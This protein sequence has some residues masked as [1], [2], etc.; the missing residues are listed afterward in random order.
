MSRRAPNLF[1]IGSMK[2]GTTYLAGL[3]AE[4]PAVFM[5]EPKEPCHFVD[6]AVL[7]RVWPAAWR[8]GYWRS[9]ELYLSL[10]AAAGDARIVGEASTAYSQVPLFDG[11]PERILSL[12][13]ESRFIYIMRDP[14]ERAISHYWHV[15][16]WWAERRDMMTAIRRE[17]HYADVSHYARQLKAYLRYVPPER[18]YT[19]TLEQL[20]AKPYE[21]VRALCFWLGIEPDALPVTMAGPL[22]LTP[23]MIEQARGFGLLHRL[24]RSSPYSRIGRFVPRPAR[25]LFAQMA[26]RRV[27]PEGEPVRQV[28]EYLRPRMQEQTQELCA[29][30]GRSFP[31][32]QTLYGA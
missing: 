15:V 8:L 27:D 24:R 30:L 31:E 16:R 11:V 20:Q 3:L 17:P 13:P 2:S 19:L 4:H 18:I 6:P 9:V 26:E 5:C 14:I 10:F 29:L 23:V 25:A 7:R 12:S 1:L 21:A 32:W 28:A 22:N